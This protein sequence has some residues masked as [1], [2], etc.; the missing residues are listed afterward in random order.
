MPRHMVFAPIPDSYGLWLL[1]GS[2]GMLYIASRAAVD[3]LAPGTGALAARRAL[4]YWLPVAAV[5]L[6]ATL[7]RR[8]EVALGVIFA[9]SVASLSLVIGIV[10]TM[11]EQEV[12]TPPPGRRAGLFVLPA[13]L[14]ALLAGFAGHLTPVHALILLVEG[15]VVLG[16]WRERPALPEKG[17]GIPL[18][19]PLPPRLNGWRMAQLALAAMLALLGAWGATGGVVAFSHQLRIFSGGVLSAG[20]LGPALLL[21][22]IGGGMAQAT[23]RQ[24]GSVLSTQVILAML[25]L[26]LLLPTVILLWHY[27]PGAWATLSGLWG[28]TITPADIPTLSYP[29]AVWRVD[30]VVL[31]VLGL[32]LLPVAGGRWSLGRWEGIGLIVGYAVYLMMVMK[33][34]TKT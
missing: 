11:S 29:L 13:A 21:P 30:N 24:G 7:A 25:N 32:L 12:I 8:P 3:A 17:D 18:A 1:I 16:V 31:V 4:G 19:H 26:C 9:S 6:M 33:M 28:T 5:A 15:I 10:S 20:I 23:R 34:G 2:V 22:T 14:L 27:G